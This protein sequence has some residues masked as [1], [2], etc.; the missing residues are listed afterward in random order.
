MQACH[1]K[2]DT[3]KTL[4]AMINSLRCNGVF[5]V[6]HNCYSKHKCCGCSPGG[7]HCVN[8]F[9]FFVVAFFPACHFATVKT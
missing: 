4:N 1:E 9:V 5:D 2:I 8:N 7:G 6:T 3:G